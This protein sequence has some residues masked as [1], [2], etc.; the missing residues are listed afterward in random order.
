MESVQQYLNGAEK[1][2]PLSS[3][4]D[5]RMEAYFSAIKVIIVL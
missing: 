4:V 1:L 5:V 2:G 3:D